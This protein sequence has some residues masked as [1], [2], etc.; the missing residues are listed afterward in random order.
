MNDF[1]E[2]CGEVPEGKEHNWQA[3]GSTEERARE[4]VEW[5]LALQRTGEHHTPTIDCGT[6]ML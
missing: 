4:L 1:C 2:I 3:H 6:R 5:K